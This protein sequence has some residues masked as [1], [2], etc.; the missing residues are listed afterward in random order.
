MHQVCVAPSPDAA[1]AI[2][3]NVVSAPTGLHRSCEFLSAVQRKKEISRRMALATVFHCLGKVGTAIPFGA[4]LNVGF[5]TLMGIKQARPE[6]HEAALV[7]RKDKS[8][9]GRRSMDG[10]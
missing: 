9:V 6:A 7:K 10:L 4:A 2:G 5:I 1:A 8:I 3:R